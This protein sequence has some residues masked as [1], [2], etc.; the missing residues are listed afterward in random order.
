MWYS[1]Q[2]PDHSA[3]SPHLLPCEHGWF[4]LEYV[5]NKP[6]QDLSSLSDKSIKDLGLAVTRAINIQQLLTA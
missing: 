1:V 5:L 4:F 2:K 3:L 6:D